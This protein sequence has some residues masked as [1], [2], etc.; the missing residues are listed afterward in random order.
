MT[1]ETTLYT[2]R[3]NKGN[4]EYRTDNY[5]TVVTINKADAENWVNWLNSRRENKNERYE[6]V[7]K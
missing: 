7:E 6:I 2:F 5:C 1:R 3:I 4:N